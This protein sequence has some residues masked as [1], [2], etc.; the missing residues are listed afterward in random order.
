M[1]IGRSFT[2]CSPP[3]QGMTLQQLWCKLLTVYRVSE[4]HRV[5]VLWYSKAEVGQR[6]RITIKLA[7]LVYFNRQHRLKTRIVRHV[8]RWVRGSRKL[9][10]ITCKLLAMRRC[11]HSMS[12]LCFL[13]T[14]SS[15]TFLETTLHIIQTSLQIID[16][17]HLSMQRTLRLMKTWQQNT[18]T[19]LNQLLVTRNT[20]FL[21]S[22][23]NLWVWIQF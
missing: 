5:T 17:L 20:S 21:Q 3:C 9:N 10:R 8:G 12:S 1:Y 14:M 13:S 22:V 11:R 18:F 23:F 19:S 16:L 4:V 6:S 15:K 2:S 7:R